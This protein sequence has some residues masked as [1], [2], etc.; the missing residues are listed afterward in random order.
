[1]A[2]VNPFTPADWIGLVLALLAL[3]YA[4]PLWRYAAAFRRLFRAAPPA[5]AAWPRVTVLVPARDEA[6]HVEACLDSIF[7]CDYPADLLDVIVMDDFSADDTARR[8]H[9]MAGR[10]GSRLT[11]IQMADVVEGEAASHKW[12]ALA[13]GLQEARGSIILTTDA[14]CTVAR[15]WVRALVGAFTSPRV[16]LVAGPVRM[17]PAPTLLGKF[18]A[19][20]FAGLIALGA[21]AMASGSPN[22]SNSAN[23]AYRRKIFEALKLV[24]R[25]ERP[26]PLD[27]ELLLFRIRQHPT[28]EAV[29]CASPDA[30]VTTPPEPSYRDFALQRWRWASKGA[31]YPGTRLALFVRYVYAFHL[32]LVA[33]LVAALVAPGLWPWVGA[34]FAFK[35]LGE[36]ALVL[37]AL[38]RYGPGGLGAWFLPFQIVQVPHVLFFGAAGAFRRPRWKGRAAP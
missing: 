14:D 21:G 8:V 16:A 10:Y 20:E 34:A 12:E 31:R 5:P 4:L 32:L 17:A 36:A 18:Q 35:V 29:F 30:L 2:L 15:G 7:A 22:M 6:D 27:D 24:A 28:L 38:R 19:A 37:P 33:A 25:T 1:M 23:L 3:G 13:W 11:L 26:L 9:A